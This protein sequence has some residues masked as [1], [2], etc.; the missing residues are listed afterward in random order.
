MDAPGLVITLGV[1][2]FFLGVQVEHEPLEDL[3]RAK[4]IRNVVGVRC[5]HLR[6]SKSRSDKLR[7]CIDGLSTFSTDTS[8]HSAFRCQYL[9]RF[10]RHQF[11]LRRLA[12]LAFYV[13][14]LP[15]LL[16]AVLEAALP[17]PAYGAEAGVGDAG[18]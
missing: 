15:R 16:R 18:V 3:R 6:S 12:A 13:T 8:F 2:E 10:K 4:R 14:H 5:T 9:G 1:V 7:R 11:N 17:R